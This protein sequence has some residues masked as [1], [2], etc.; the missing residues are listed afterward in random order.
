MIIKVYICVFHFNLNIYYENVPN[1]WD[2]LEFLKHEIYTA[3]TSIFLQSLTGLDP[4]WK[5]SCKLFLDSKTENNNKISNKLMLLSVCGLT[6]N[7]AYT[8]IK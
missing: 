7:D 2:G 5:I 8:Q 3:H 4:K 1:T 6:V